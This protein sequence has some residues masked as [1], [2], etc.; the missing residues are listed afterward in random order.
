[1]ENLR[2]VKRVNKDKVYVDE[3]GKE[4]CSVNYYL[5]VNGNYIAIRPS[6][7]KGYY[8]LDTIAEV[9]KNGECNK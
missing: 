9:V 3:K 1:M 8:M 2:I 7:H 4:R 5:V 6:F